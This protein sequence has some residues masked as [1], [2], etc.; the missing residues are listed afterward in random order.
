MQ[1]CL[2]TWL[3]L[4]LWRWH[5]DELDEAATAENEEHCVEN[6]QGQLRKVHI[7]VPNEKTRIS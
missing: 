4:T 2:T 1:R 5:I 3:K 7:L 6:G